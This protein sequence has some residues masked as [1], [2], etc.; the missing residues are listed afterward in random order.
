MKVDVGKTIKNENGGK[1]VE[2]MN[3]LDI[4]IYYYQRCINGLQLLLSISSREIQ[5]GEK[6]KYYKMAIVTINDMRI[7]L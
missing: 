6:K 7:Q 2:K 5:K 1:Y 3:L 4:K